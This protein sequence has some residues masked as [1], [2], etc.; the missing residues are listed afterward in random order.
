MAYIMAKK[1]PKNVPDTLVDS[2]MFSEGPALTAQERQA[3][4]RE[5][6]RAKREEKRQKNRE[7]FAALWER[8]APSSESRKATLIL[9]SLILIVVLFAVVI[10]A[11]QLSPGGQEMKPG[12]NYY[13][14]TGDLPS[15][16]EDSFASINEIYYTQ[17][18]GVQVY[19]T[20]AN[21]YLTAQR[22]VRIQVKIMN[23]EDKVIAAASHDSIPENFF[24]VEQGYEAYQL[25]IPKKYV[26]IADDPLTSIKYDV[27]VDYVEY[28]KE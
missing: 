17:N 4:A 13:V 2:I 22:P 18:G 19:L 15:M 8:I 6:K 9:L 1:T 26:E 25:F 28:V 5:Q 12:S 14:N 3:L 21:P 11:L 23:G 10:L 7:L 24:I 20:L 16:E 27:I